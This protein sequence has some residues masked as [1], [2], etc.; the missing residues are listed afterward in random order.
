MITWPLLHNTIRGNSVHNTFGLVRQYANGQKKPHQGWDLR[1]VV[2]TPVYAV[3]SGK[4]VFVQHQGDYGLQVCHSFTFR[5]RVLYAFYAHLLSTKVA[6]GNEVRT[7][8]E[9]A[10]TGKSGNAASLKAAEDHLHFEIREHPYTGLGLAGRLSPL[11]LYGHCPLT[12]IVLGDQQ[13]V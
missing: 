11:A 2:G 10:T 9:I 4:V 1:A 7:D 8:Q 5:G 6:A 13:I 12:Q 3:G